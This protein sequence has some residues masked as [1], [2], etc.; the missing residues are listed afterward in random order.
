MWKNLIQI[1]IIKKV[2]DTGPGKDQK[3]DIV[4]RGKGYFRLAKIFFFP[5]SQSYSIREKDI[6]KLQ[7]NLEKNMLVLGG[8]NWWTADF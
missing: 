1:W 2:C 5:D 7:K 3:D 4:L 6:K 8:L